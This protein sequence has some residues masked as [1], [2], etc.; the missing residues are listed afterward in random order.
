[1]IS[2]IIPSLRRVDCCKWC[3]YSENRHCFSQNN[4]YC[5]LYNITVEDYEICDTYKMEV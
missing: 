1:M 3:C 2:E 4:N 5:N